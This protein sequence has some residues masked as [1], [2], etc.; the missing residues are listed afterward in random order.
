M[1]INKRIELD[2]LDCEVV[3]GD[4]VVLGLVPDH[5]GVMIG[6]RSEGKV[7]GGQL[8]PTFARQFAADMLNLADE[9]EGTNGR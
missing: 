8:S 6:V 7:H 3:Q 4:L 5:S 1:E 9:A 2:S